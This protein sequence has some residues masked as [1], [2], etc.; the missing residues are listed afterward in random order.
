MTRPRMRAATALALLATIGLTACK[1]PEGTGTAQDATDSGGRITVWVDPPRVP[2]VNAF[3][4]AFPDIPVEVNTIN[5][6]VGSTELQQKFV[7]FNQAGKGWPDAIFFPSNDDIA[8]AT[9]SKINYVRDLRP[10]WPT[11]SPTTRRASIEQCKSTGSTAACATMPHP[12]CSGTTR[13]CSAVGLPNRRRRGSSTRAQ[14]AHR[15]RTPRLPHRFPRRRLRAGPLPLGQ[16]MPHQRPLSE[17]HVRIDL[18]DPHACGSATCSTGCCPPA[19]R[20]RPASSP[21]TRPNSAAA[22]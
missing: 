9:S 12:T 1:G 6:N 18:A 11:S 4:Q 10:T 16:W 5:G 17:K 22:S 19:P 7:L 15:R 14:P 20:H 13:C 3:Q 21:R 8:W 2:A